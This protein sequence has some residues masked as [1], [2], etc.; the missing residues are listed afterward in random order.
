M[1]A[2]ILKK[3]LFCSSCVQEIFVPGVP[4]HLHTTT[5]Y[6][7]LIAHAVFQLLCD[8]VTGLKFNPVLYPRVSVFLEIYPHIFRLEIL[9]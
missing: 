9:V 5:V 6:M 4:Q 7:C 1:C 3:K 2:F 8:D